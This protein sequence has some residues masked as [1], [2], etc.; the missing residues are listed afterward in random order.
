M[1]KFDQKP[2]LITAF[3]PLILFVVAVLAA[4]TIVSLPVVAQNPTTSP[5]GAPASNAPSSGA[6]TSGQSSGQ[7]DDQSVETLKVNV[8]VVQLFFL[9]LIHI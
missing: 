2:W 3:F 5:S 8:E 1:R 6:N 4:V 7:S 9:S